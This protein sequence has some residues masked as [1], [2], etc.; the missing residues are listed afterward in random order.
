MSE[1]VE[2]STS[3]AQ[4]EY[5]SHVTLML[6]GD[7]LDPNR[8]TRLLALRP[9]KAWTKDDLK[10]TPGG[11]T[12]SSESRHKWG[13]WKKSLPASL[14]TRPLP[15]QLRYWARKLTSK[16]D[17]LSVLSAQGY[18]CALNCYVATSETASINMPAEL[19]AQVAAL[20]LEIRLAFFA[21][22]NT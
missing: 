1:N 4:P 21:S 18:V 3:L 6:L 12:L 8:V 20:G 7:D 22:G 5:T 16:V 9:T 14:V 19:Q 15:S 10:R 17:A 11:A 2:M 13:G